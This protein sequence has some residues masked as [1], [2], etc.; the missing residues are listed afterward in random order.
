MSTAHAIDPDRD[1]DRDIPV[2]EDNPLKVEWETYLDHKRELLAHEGQAVLIKG[3]EI[4][5][6]YPTEDEAVAEGSRR[7]PLEGF[8][9]HTIHRQE[10]IVY[11]GGAG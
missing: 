7:W 6:I 5:G 9:A 1:P 8:M 10:P 3:R 4:I 2:A 11:L